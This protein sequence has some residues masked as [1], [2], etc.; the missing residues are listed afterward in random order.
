M[1]N[2]PINIFKKNLKFYR[3]QKGLTQ[4]KLSEISGISSDYISEMER[5]KKT[6]SFK[7]LILLA[8]ALDIEIYKLFLDNG[9]KNFL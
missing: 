1:T 5:G 4:E 7:R 8:N 9:R 6:P 2:S 3:T